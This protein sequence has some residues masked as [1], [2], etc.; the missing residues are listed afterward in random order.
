M[1]DF[2]RIEFFSR[3]GHTLVGIN[4]AGFERIERVVDL[5]CEGSITGLYGSFLASP[6]PS[7]KTASITNTEAKTMIVYARLMAPPF[8]ANAKLMIAI[9]FYFVTLL[10]HSL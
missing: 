1:G 4:C 3:V 8:N 10:L 6:A 9:P 2:D 5:R 7:T